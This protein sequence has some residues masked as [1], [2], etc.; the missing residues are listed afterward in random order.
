VDFV[1]EQTGRVSVRE[2]DLPA[3]VIV[4]YVMALALYMQSTSQ[5][6]CVACSKEWMAVGPVRR[7]SKVAGKPGTSQARTRLGPEPG[8][9]G[10]TAAYPEIRISALL[11]NGTHVLCAARMDRVSHP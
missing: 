2:S 9:A 6:C 1:L 3:R 7:R 8:K 5:R 4:Y 10:A 11:E